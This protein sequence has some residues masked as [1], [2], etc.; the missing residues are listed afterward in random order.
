MSDHEK[1]YYTEMDRIFQTCT[2]RMK[3]CPVEYRGR[4]VTVSNKSLMERDAI[5]EM[6]EEQYDTINYAVMLIQQLERTRERM[7]KMDV[8]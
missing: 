2:E 4:D 8:T 7:A 3:D 1:R 5:Q 6:I